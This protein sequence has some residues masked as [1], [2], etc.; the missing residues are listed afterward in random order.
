MSEK[1]QTLE[2]KQKRFQNEVLSFNRL[3]A[4]SPRN[5][6]E[7]M[8]MSISSIYE[9]LSE[10]QRQC[11]PESHQLKVLHDGTQYSLFLRHLVEQQICSTTND[12]LI[13]TE[14]DTWVIDM[15]KGISLSDIKFVL[16]GP[17]QC[18]KTTLLY[19]LSKLLMKKIQVSDQ[20]NTYLFF[21]FNF[22]LVTWESNFNILRLFISAIFDSLEYSCLAL[23]PYIKQLRQWFTM[24]V[25]GS[26][27]QLPK[28]VSSLPPPPQ[29]EMKSHVD[30]DR[31][32]KLANS[33]NKCMKSTEK[34]GLDNFLKSICM[35]P[36]QIAQAVGLNGVIYFLDSFEFSSYNFTPNADFF[37]NSLRPVSFS[38]YLCQEL[39]QPDILYI[40]SPQDEEQFLQ[41]FTCNDGALIDLEGILKDFKIPT[42]IKVTLPQLHITID[43]CNGYPG[44]IY[45]FYNLCNLISAM[46]QNTTSALYSVIKNSS[47]VSRHNTVKRELLRFCQLLLYSGSTLVSEELMQTIAEEQ[48]IKITVIGD[49]VEE[50]E[51][52]PESQRSKSTSP[53]S[54]KGMKLSAA[55]SVVTDVTD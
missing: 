43:H 31:L 20:A 18:G 46:N 53:S 45:K 21:P 4:S 17:R 32:T 12:P 30:V 41:C 2:K 48:N 11:L 37:P 38:K 54:V 49:D 26:N 19:S 6:E 44:Y 7:T 25:F 16:T 55:H 22:K 50:E 3:F 40:V 47:A 8:R 23:L 33:L 36:N 5:L 28:Q 34:E 52:I 1:S 29:S 51:E 10:N 35:L 42:E 13:K 24:T 14:L 39:D 15:L 9:Q 27:I